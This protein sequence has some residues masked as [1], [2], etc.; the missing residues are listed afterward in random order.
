MRLGEVGDFF[1]PL[2]NRKIRFGAFHI[3]N[4][5]MGFGIARHEQRAAIG[6]IH[7]R[8][9]EST[10]FLRAVDDIELVAADERAEYGH[11]DDSVR[12]PNVLERLRSNLPKTLAC[13]KSAGVFAKRYLLG[14][15]EHQAP[16]D[17]D[18]QRLWNRKRDFLLVITEWNDVHA[19][20]TP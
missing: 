19:R 18:A 7:G 14:N 11:I 12:R 3:S 4:L 6:S 15:A 17:Y 16:V 1:Y 8:D 5:G 10:E 2:V 13:Y 9:F 20:D